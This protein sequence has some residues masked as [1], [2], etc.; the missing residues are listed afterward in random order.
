MNIHF[1]EHQ[2]FICSNDLSLVLVPQ[3]IKGKKKKKGVVLGGG[4][5]A[6]GKDDLADYG[7]FD[8]GYT[9]DYDDFM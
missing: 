1:E 2:L 9:Q 4:M 6:K 8:G 5:K 3:A 7:E